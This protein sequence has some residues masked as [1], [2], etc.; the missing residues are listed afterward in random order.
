MMGFRHFP[1]SLATLVSAVL[2]MEQRRNRFKAHT[3]PLFLCLCV[4]GFRVS[5]AAVR[6]QP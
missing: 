5:M 1:R 4:F 2:A 6:W 3:V